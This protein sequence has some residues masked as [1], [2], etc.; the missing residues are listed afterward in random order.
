MYFVLCFEFRY[1]PVDAL[2]CCCCRPVYSVSEVATAVL[3]MMEK[4]CVSKACF[5]AHSYGERRPDAPG[6]FAG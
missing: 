1:S 6:W 5:V 4:M 3:G 2:P